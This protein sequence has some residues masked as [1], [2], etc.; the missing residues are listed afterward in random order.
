MYSRRMDPSLQGNVT[1]C[2]IL[3]RENLPNTKRLTHYNKAVTFETSTL[4]RDPQ[5][6]T[7][8]H[9]WKKSTDRELGWLVI[10]QEKNQNYE[11][12]CLIPTQS[13]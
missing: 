12:L 7:G 1:E 6:I 2:M 4:Y 9:G 3:V 5:Q 11:D 13:S 8:T 10:R